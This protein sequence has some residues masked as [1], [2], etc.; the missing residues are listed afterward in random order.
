MSGDVISTTVLGPGHGRKARYTWP[1]LLVLGRVGI[2]F[3]VPLGLLVVWILAGRCNLLPQQILPPPITVIAALRS[4]WSDG[5]LPQDVLV[6]LGRVAKGFVAG[7]ALGAITGI[8]FGLSPIARKTCEPVFIGLAQI[9]VLGWLPILVL[10]AGLGDAPKII[11]IAWACFIPVVLNTR[12]GIRDVSPGFLELGRAICLGP[13]SM[14][15]TIILPAAVPQI[16]TGLR[17]GLA[18]GWQTLVA[19]ELIGSFS[20]LGYMMAYGRQLFQLD[21]VLAAVLV[22]GMIG[23]ALHTLL[24]LLER[25]LLYWQTPR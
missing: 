12:Q 22:I 3:V 15:S 11:A 10:F 4:G 5:S 13:F 18:N 9:P 19:V 17:E 14:L 1:W 16:F 7:A 6:S 23:L 20:G 2:G 21:V 25:R 8:V 24:A